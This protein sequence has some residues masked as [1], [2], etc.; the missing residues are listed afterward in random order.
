MAYLQAD[1]SLKIIGQVSVQLSSRHISVVNITDRH[2]YTDI[3]A[4]VASTCILE[5]TYM[6]LFW[7]QI[8]CSFSQH[9]LDV[10]I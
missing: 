4:R 5:S 2:Y 10:L 3:V 7:Q 1:M 9:Q 8:K 6:T